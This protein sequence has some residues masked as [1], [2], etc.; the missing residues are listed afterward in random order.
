M[1]LKQTNV[2]GEISIPAEAIAQ[3]A[4]SIAVKCYGVVGM[5]LRNKRDGLASLLKKEN[6]SKGIKVTYDNEKLDIDIHIIS[7]YGVNMN[8]ISKNIVSGVKYYIEHMVGFNVNMINVIVE[9]IRV[10]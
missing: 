1:V 3:I 6:M 5:A 9:S 8:E 2:Y 10:D 4:G 7:E